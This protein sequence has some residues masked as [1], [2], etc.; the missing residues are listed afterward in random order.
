MIVSIQALKL[1]FCHVNPFRRIS[2]SVQEETLHSHS[3]NAF[4]TVPTTEMTRFEKIWK[5]DVRVACKN[6]KA[7]FDN[8]MLE[9]RLLYHA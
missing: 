1:S 6:C 7:V 2:Q 5:S 3:N 8:C 9:A 4:V